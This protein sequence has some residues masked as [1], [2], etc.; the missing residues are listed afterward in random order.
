M[1]NK[2]SRGP[3]CKLSHQNMPSDCAQCR[4][5]FGLHVSL[6]FGGRCGRLTG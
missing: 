6:M 4:I 3:P 1:S 2:K 5:A